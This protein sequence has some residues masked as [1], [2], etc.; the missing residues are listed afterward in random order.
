MDRINELLVGVTDLPKEEIYFIIDHASRVAP[1][2]FQALTI[3]LAVLA[4]IASGSRLLFRWR[5]EDPLRLEDYLVLFATICLVVE[6]GLVYSF[7]H[8][9]Y[10]I[11]AAT[12]H[13]SV[14]SYVAKDPVLAQQLLETGSTLVAYFSLGWTAIFAIK[15]S[16]LALFYRMLRNVCGKLTAYFW[17]TVAATAISFVVI[18]LESFILCPKFGADAAQCFMKDNYTFSISSGVVVQVLDIV[19]DLMIISIPIAL[20]RMCRLQLQH[21]LRIAVV[22]CLSGTC[23]ILSLVRLA[24]GL[25]RNVFGKMQFGVTWISFMLHCE[26]AVAVM[27]GSVPA[28]RAVYT[29]HQHRKILSGIVADDNSLKSKT[30]SVLGLTKKPSQTLPVQ[31]K[32]PRPTST[33]MA[34]WRQSIVRAI[35]K[36]MASKRGIR[37]LTYTSDSR[38]GS[39]ESA[40]IHPTVAYH[41]FRRQENNQIRVT[42]ETTVS[43]EDGSSW[44]FSEACS[45]TGTVISAPNSP[46][47]CSNQVMAF[48]EP[49]V[50]S[51]R[52]D[53]IIDQQFGK[54]S[55]GMH[56]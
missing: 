41:D 8:R 20:L 10:V 48:P 54:I 44:N 17:C 22:L 28:L 43:S 15:S 29:S 19:T 51:Q 25:Q 14:L 39:A 32:A 5:N 21:K 2:A 6:T 1:V 45:K 42:Y 47:T 55:A 31:E 36:R 56:L 33:P 37:P 30:M 23:I 46:K 50:T 13:L 12:T 11:D 7:T 49:V 18:I 53:Y 26:A 27:A 24:A 52:V 9:L 3:F 38:K 40:I 4:I 16:F 35:P 34:K